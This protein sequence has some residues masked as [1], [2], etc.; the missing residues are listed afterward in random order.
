MP[1]QKHKV[2]AG[3]G[4]G[5]AGQSQAPKAIQAAKYPIPNLFPDP[6]DNSDEGYAP[7]KKATV[8]KKPVKRR[9][10]KAIRKDIETIEISSDD[11]IQSSGSVPPRP[12][13]MPTIPVGFTPTNEANS[14]NGAQAGNHQLGIAAQESA[15]HRASNA[16]SSARPEHVKPVLSQDYHSLLFA[17]HENHLAVNNF[18]PRSQDPTKVVTVGAGRLQYQPA[19]LDRSLVST[20]PD[21]SM[22]MGSRSH[23]LQHPVA[24]HAVSEAGSSHLHGA[25]TVRLAPKALLPSFSEAFYHEQRETR[26]IVMGGISSFDLSAMDNDNGEPLRVGTGHHHAESMSQM[27]DQYVLSSGIPQYD[28]YVAPARY[29]SSVA[30]PMMQQV[31]TAATAGRLPVLAPAPAVK[32]EEMLQ[33]PAG[34]PISNMPGDGQPQGPKKRVAYAD[35]FFV[36][37]E[38]GGV[39]QRGTGQSLK[40]EGDDKAESTCIKKEDVQVAPSS[41][42]MLQPH[43]NTQFYFPSPREIFQQAAASDRN[44]TTFVNQQAQS[45][46][47]ASTHDNQVNTFIHRVQHP[48]MPRK[49]ATP[50]A[51]KAKSPEKT[52]AYAVGKPKSPAK[53]PAPATGRPKSPANKKLTSW[54][55]YLQT[56]DGQ[57]LQHGSG[58]KKKKPDMH[59]DMLASNASN[60]ALPRAR[61]GPRTPPEP[62]PAF[63]QTIT[64]YYT[65]APIPQATPDSLTQ[66]TLKRKGLV[67]ADARHN[68]S[69]STAFAA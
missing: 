59:I 13:L 39:E 18:V 3:P 56:P 12:A 27:T 35:S 62:H 6:D 69:L 49:K 16:G 24:P 58:S 28:G 2:N 9:E 8:P 60:M 5:S 67:L 36:L 50:T 45:H 14:T 15:H 65:P 42:E 64:Q 31:R 46:A 26:N 63:R 34:S 54:D 61:N 21:Y 53:K 40:D 20:G 33:K 68:A 30:A 55:K 57:I 17:D 29:D 23:G 66:E 51:E 44:I 52:P 38:G 19:S 41:A 47:Q 48:I 10:K 1:P 7:V 43:H 32:K 4:I 22:A 37:G 11:D 25:T